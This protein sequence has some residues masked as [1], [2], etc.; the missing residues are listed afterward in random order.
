MDS[1]QNSNQTTESNI[2]LVV[3]FDL[4][5]RW[6]RSSEI[7]INYQ[8]VWCHILEDSTFHV[9]ELVT[10]YLPVRKITEHCTQDHGRRQRGGGEY[11]RDMSSRIFGKNKNLKEE[12]MWMYQLLTQKDFSHNLWRNLY[13]SSE[14]YSSKSIYE[15]ILI[16]LKHETVRKPPG[17]PPPQKTNPGA[18]WLPHC[19]LENILAEPVI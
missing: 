14:T 11:K 18:D 17:N 5:W 19:P 10:W 4:S 7:S 6:Q 9:Y 12:K 2:H 1:G 3:R 13:V 16:S 8:T 15:S